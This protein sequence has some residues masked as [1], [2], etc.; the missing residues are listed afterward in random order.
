MNV[1]DLVKIEIPKDRAN[2]IIDNVMMEAGTRGAETLGDLRDEELALILPLMQ[3]VGITFDRELVE[4]ANA[5]YRDGYVP[6]WVEQ[7]K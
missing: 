5:A 6:S 2:H 3:S 7:P 4:R 1:E